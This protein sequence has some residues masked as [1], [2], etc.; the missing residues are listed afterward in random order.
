MYNSI[1]E[2]AMRG[3]FTFLFE[4]NRPEVQLT[5]RLSGKEEASA[6]KE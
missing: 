2:T 3:E 5:R 4:G 6:I 1:I